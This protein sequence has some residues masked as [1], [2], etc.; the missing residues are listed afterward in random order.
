[1][2]IFIGFDGGG[3]YSRYIVQKDEATPTLHHFEESIKPSKHSVIHTAGR[4]TAHLQEILSEEIA[5][6]CSIAISISGAGS[7]ERKSELSH[8]I[9][10]TLSLPSQN[11]FVESDSLFGLE[12]S[13]QGKDNAGIFCIVGSGSVI[14]AR[15]YQNTIL[16]VGGWGKQFGDQGSAFAIGIA[17]MRY[18][19]LAADG[20]VEKGF[21]F[22]TIHSHLESKSHELGMSIRDYIQSGTITILE[23]ARI[24]LNGQ[25]DDTVGR[26]IIDDAIREIVTA[27]L[28]FYSKHQNELPMFVTLHGGLLQTPYYQETMLNDLEHHGFRFQILGT[29]HLL[30]YTLKKARTFAG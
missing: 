16:R 28:S 24:T 23:V 17:S 10:S 5:H 9:S 27:I 29:A 25:R 11:V 3:T 13:Y 12:A 20:L 22:D 30:D 4:I 2:N 19:C 18:Y 6:I 21:L 15:T 14:T 26:G 1:M 8:R 7:P